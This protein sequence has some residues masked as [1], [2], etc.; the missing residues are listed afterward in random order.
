MNASLDAVVLAFDGKHTKDLQKIVEVS[1]SDVTQLLGYFDKDDHQQDA[2]SWVILN[3]VSS[4]GLELSSAQISNLLAAAGG[5]TSWGA[6]L[7]VA[8][9]LHR[10]EIDARQAAVAADLLR[11]YAASTKP[12]VLAWSISAL[13]ECAKQLP[14]L[15]SEV[16]GL[17]AKH[18]DHSSASV[19]AR[20]RKLA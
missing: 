6:Q 7:H 8:Q 19:R 11:S 20:L 16:K 18:K 1:D 13:A 4:Q 10:V 5:L 2:A 17:V 12:M 3:C 15:E 9:L 14:A